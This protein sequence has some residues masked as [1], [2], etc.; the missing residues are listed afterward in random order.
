LIGVGEG[1]ISALV[2]ASVLRLRPELLEGRAEAAVATNALGVRVRSGLGLGLAIAVLLAPLASTA[3]DGLSRV[4][5]QLGFHPTERRVP[6]AP[7][8]AYEI[9]GLGSGALTT[10]ACA[11]VGVLLL[12]GLCWLL[13]LGL[14]PRSRRAAR[15]AEQVAVESSG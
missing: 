4:A 9:P 3:P 15:S 7:L 13:A 11:A 6:F 2:V 14:V 8:S 1:V 5:A 10:L 12:F